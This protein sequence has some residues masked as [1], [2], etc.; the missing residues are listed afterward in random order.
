MGND[1]SENPEPP[2]SNEFTITIDKGGDPDAK[3]GL[4][5]QRQD[6]G[7]VCLKIKK[8]KPGHIMNWNQAH[9]EQQVMPDDWIIKVNNDCSSSEKLLEK[10]AKDKKCVLVIKRPA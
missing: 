6:E 8:V 4:D 7:T 5:V 1:Q 3:I 2:S 9:P 10:I